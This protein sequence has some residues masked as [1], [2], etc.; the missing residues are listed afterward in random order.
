MTPRV[1][2]ASAATAFLLAL[3]SVP[4]MAQ[5][6]RASDLPPGEGKDTLLRACSDCHGM[7]VIEGQRRTRKQWRDSVEDMVARGADASERD[8]KG[9]VDYLTSALGRVNVNR[10]SQEEIHAVVDLTPADAAAIVE[11][12]QR[13]GE[14]KSLDD[15]KKVPG[16][17]VTKLESRKDRIVLSGE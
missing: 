9:I 2:L 4:T 13:H 3:M 14:F 1:L 12:R 6:G 7:E 16:L 11:Y 10:A 5:V 17:D 15:V 8:V